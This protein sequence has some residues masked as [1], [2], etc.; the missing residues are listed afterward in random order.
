MILLLPVE[1]FVEAI[2]R[3]VKPTRNRK[4]IVEV[5]T[6]SLNF[7]MYLEELDVV[8]TGLVPN[9]KAG[10][11]QTNHCWRFVRRMESQPFLSEGGGAGVKNIGDTVTTFFCHT[12]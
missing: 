6:G 4:L 9:P 5:L 11:M 12:I 2:R 10:Q 1:D 7:K 3:L 8:I